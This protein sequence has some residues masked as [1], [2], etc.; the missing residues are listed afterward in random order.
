MRAITV[1][2]R[3]YRNHYGFYYFRPKAAALS[4]FS[5]GIFAQSK[6]Y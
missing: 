4:Y 2:G 5:G 6:L 1:R 3:V